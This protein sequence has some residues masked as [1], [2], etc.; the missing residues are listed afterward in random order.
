MISPED[1]ALFQY[2]D[3]PA[4]ALDLLQKGLAIDANAATPDFAGSRSS[5]DEQKR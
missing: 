4:T 2:V 5:D 1:V 3:D